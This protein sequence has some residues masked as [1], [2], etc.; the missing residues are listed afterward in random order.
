[1]DVLVIT[2]SRGEWGYIKPILLLMEKDKNINYSLCATNMHL[3]PELG[4]S[5]NEIEKDGF[6]IDY[7]IYMA[8]SGSN[9]LTQLKS[10][11]LFLSSLADI[12][13][14]K[15][16][17]FILLAGD[18]GEQL[19]GAIAG[20]YTY[21][22]TGHIQ[23]GEVS[24]NIDGASRHAIGKLV[25]LHFASNKDAFD[26]LVKLGEEKR[27]IFNTGAPQLDE[28][29]KENLVSKKELQKVYNFDFN[30]KFALVV[31]HPVTEEY[32]LAKKQI[33]TTFEALNNFEYN[34]V[35]V[36]PIMMLEV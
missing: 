11:A 7:K 35:V 26:R 3:M 4:L 31:Q 2:G 6:K 9:H 23:A 20:A 15:K 36:M 28:I 10:L 27:R 13:S 19:M 30:K 14:S 34:L 21:I 8:L 22:P 1:M 25:H 18:R 12:L 29:K 24:G 16:F 33:R 5:V 32:S 17:D